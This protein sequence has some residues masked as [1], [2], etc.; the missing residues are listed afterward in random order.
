MK[1][2]ETQMA[3]A[4]M[5]TSSKTT[6]R[7]DIVSYLT[8]ENCKNNGQSVVKIFNE[9]RGADTRSKKG[10]VMTDQHKAVN[11]SSQLWALEQ[12]DYLI[13][14]GDD[15]SHTTLSMIASPDGEVFKGAEELAE[16]YI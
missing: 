4:K 9:T 8:K 12:D 10:L 13:E 16:K 7:E 15:G 5:K 11:M 14:R 6:W 3:I 1:L 2:D